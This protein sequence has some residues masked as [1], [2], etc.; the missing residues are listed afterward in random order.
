MTNT[1]YI[2]THEVAVINQCKGWYYVTTYIFTTPEEIR[3]VY[4]YISFHSDLSSWACGTIL[5]C[6]PNWILTKVYPKIYL[7]ILWNITFHLYVSTFYSDTRWN[8][9]KKTSQRITY[10]FSSIQLVEHMATFYGL[11]SFKVDPHFFSSQP[12]EHLIP[13]DPQFIFWP[14]QLSM[15]YHFISV[16]HFVPWEWNVLYSR[17]TNFELKD[18]QEC[19]K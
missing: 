3:V 16:I 17:N 13:I 15:W 14:K 1:R 8:E 4:R 18:K 11:I 10:I 7:S 9:V 19:F 2:D 5:F 12:V 6:D